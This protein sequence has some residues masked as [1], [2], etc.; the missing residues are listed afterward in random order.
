MT[1]P[2]EAPLILAIET[3]TRAGS[4]SL[5]R[6]QNILSTITGDAASSH[7]KDLLENV[8]T[9]LRRGRANLNEVDVF[10]AA[11]GP[12]SFT[13]LRIGM[14]TTKSFAANTGK[15]CIGVSTLA[16]IAHA[17]RAST[18]YVVA[19]LPAGRGEVFA[20]MFSTANNSLEGVDR[21]AHIS[22]KTL[23]ER[24]GDQSELTWAGEGAHAH[25]G[26][27]R[28]WADDHGI[29]FIDESDLAQ[30]DRVWILAELT[31]ELAPSIAAL[32]LSEYERGHAVSP[33]ELHAHYVRPSDAEIG[34]PWLLHKS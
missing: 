20:Q 26:I 33:Q 31:I 21:A 25:A 10:A 19:L 6:G 12:G 16:A 30:R 15:Q 18:E 13:G 5:A 9:V 7:S 23:L 4:M 1:V 2:I 17:A 28:N 24:Y 29:G 3:A 32:A 22:P 27:L 14:A 34:K 11:S 8:D